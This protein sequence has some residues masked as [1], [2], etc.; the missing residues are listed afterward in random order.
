MPESRHYAGSTIS[1]RLGLVITAGY[2]GE[3]AESCTNMSLAGYNN[4]V[5]GS[6]TQSSTMSTFDGINFD[7]ST[8]P[9]FPEGV[10]DHHNCL[11]ALDDDTLLSIGGSGYDDRVLRYTIGDS[12]WVSLSSPQVGREGSGCG[13]V[14]R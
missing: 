8:V 14:T 7:T 10:E 9:D 2:S 13:L 3:R 12:G 4:D 1:T 6:F 11:V 5:V